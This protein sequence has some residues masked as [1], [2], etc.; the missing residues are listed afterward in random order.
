MIMAKNLYLEKL[1]QKEKNQRTLA[2]LSEAL[3]ARDEEIRV[4][5]EKLTNDSIQGS[6]L[7]NLIIKAED[8]SKLIKNY[9]PL[10]NSYDGGKDE[11]F[12]EQM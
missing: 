2:K 12:Q 9:T 4:L 3:K 1:K 11:D 6:V 5:S 8:K 10:D 7:G